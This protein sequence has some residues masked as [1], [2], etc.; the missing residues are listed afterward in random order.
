[1]DRKLTEE[2]SQRWCQVEKGNNDKESRHKV[3]G[4]GDQAIEG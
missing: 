3:T 2:G 4:G 1:M